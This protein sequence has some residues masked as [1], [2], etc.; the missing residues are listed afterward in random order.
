MLQAEVVKI[1]N[2]VRNNSLG[3]VVFWSGVFGNEAWFMA[4]Y[5]SNFNYKDDAPRDKIISK[6]SFPSIE[7]ALNV[8][9]NT[10]VARRCP[11][12]K[13]YAKSR[14]LSKYV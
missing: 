7:T 13:T 11:L 4:D 3:T 9:W 10:L 1:D 8:K 5:G 6:V 2:H 12:S 14:I